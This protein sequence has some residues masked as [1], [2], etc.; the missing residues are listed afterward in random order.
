[1]DMFVTEILQ[2]AFNESKF[3]DLLA[4]Y[5]KCI[6]EVGNAKTCLDDKSKIKL[7]KF[8]LSSSGA[9]EVLKSYLS[10]LVASIG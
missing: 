6:A 5:A 9:S 7:A 1:L 10:D 2:L 4:Q 8:V 3:T